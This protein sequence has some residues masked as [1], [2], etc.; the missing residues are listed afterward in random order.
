MHEFLTHTVFIFLLTVS[1]YASYCEMQEGRWGRSFLFLCMFIIV[2]SA[3]AMILF[4]PY[5]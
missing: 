3:Y 4:Q 5:A 1:M 2:A